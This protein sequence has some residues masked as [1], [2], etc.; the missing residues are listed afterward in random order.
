MERRKKEGRWKMED[1]RWDI[2]G[3]KEQTSVRIIITLFEL[4]FFH[5]LFEPLFAADFTGG[6]VR[7]KGRAW[8]CDD[9]LPG[10]SGACGGC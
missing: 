8:R 10:G 9:Y 4:G 6:G 2:V 3:E 1:G 5:H 7:D